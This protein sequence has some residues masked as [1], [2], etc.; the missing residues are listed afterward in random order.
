LFSSFIYRQYKHVP[1]HSI[2]LKLREKLQYECIPTYHINS[3]ENTCFAKHHLVTCSAFMECIP[4]VGWGMTA[5]QNSGKPIFVL[6][7]WEFILW[8]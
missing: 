4:N 7:K 8:I 5:Q 3:Y 2:I 6:D 1:T